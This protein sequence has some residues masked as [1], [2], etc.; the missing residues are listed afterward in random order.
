MNTFRK[1]FKKIRKQ[2]ASNIK[3]VV[4]CVLAATTFWILN[5]LNKDDYTTVVDQ[6]IEF[7]YNREAYRAIE[8]LPSQ[9]EI[10]IYGN[11]WDLLRKYFKFNVVPFPIEL[12]DPSA[13]NYLLTS[14][15]H[16]ALAEQIAPTQLSGILEDTLNINIDTVIEERIR[17][18]LDT[19]VNPLARNH[20]FASEITLDPD[21]VSLKGPSSIIEK[22][23][24]KITV[25]LEENN[26]GEDFSESIPLSIPNESQ[27][28]LVLK[29][30]SVYVEF[31]VVE[32]LEGNRKL[33]IQKINFPAT[34]ALEDEVSTVM[35]EF[36]VDER[37]VDG[38]E[39]LELEALLNY[40]NRNREDSTVSVQLNKAPTYLDSITFD[41]EKFKLVY[42]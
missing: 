8:D 32:F 39:E 1:Y 21:T 40:N 12:S 27:D 6:P 23:E 4:L 5:A 16:R 2:K 30:E 31:E 7:F 26:V 3:V 22:M 9:I 20:R 24:G 25:Q 42:E 33:D 29:E 15:F 38:F 10:E 34:V 17:V 28:F 11:G 35:M 41:P 13:Q 36:L 19:S 18:E 37:E 14:S